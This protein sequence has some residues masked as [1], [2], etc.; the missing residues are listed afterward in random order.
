MDVD[1]LLTRI[2]AD[3]PAAPTS[4]AL[5]ALHRAYAWTMPSEDYDIHLG[6]PISLRPDDIADKLIH[7]QRGGYCYELNGLFAALLRELGFGVTLFSA[8]SLDEHGTR[9]PDFDHLRLL[10]ETV[11]GPWLADV[12]NGGTW[13]EPVP[14]QPGTYGDVQV[15]H[16]DDLWWTAQHHSDGRWER[17][18]AWQETPRELADFAERSDHHEHDPDSY[19]RARR[20][21]VLPLPDRRISL[22]NGVFS[23]VVDGVRTER[24]VSPDEERTLLAE[25]FGIVLDGP[26]GVLWPQLDAPATA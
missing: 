13:I 2:G 10:V 19:F 25:R 24:A 12:G 15:H 20:F 4:A 8:F 22:L 18:W 26:P 17:A 3:R 1:A 16:E 5:T 23:E 14:R 21:A 11:D 7:R 6:V 9:G